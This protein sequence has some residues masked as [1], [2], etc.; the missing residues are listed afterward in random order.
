MSASVYELYRQGRQRLDGGDA[1]A[2]AEVLELAVELQP[3]QASLHEA[4]GRAYFA[5]S[6]VARARAQFEHALELHPTDDYAHFGVGRCYEREGRLGD[7]AKYYKL[8]LALAPRRDYREALDRV[9]ERL[10]GARGSQA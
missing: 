9:Q 6:R 8:A 10:A 3:Q 1:V 5:T 2:A 7:A 4:L